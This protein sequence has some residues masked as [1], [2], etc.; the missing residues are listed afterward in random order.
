MTDALSLFLEDATGLEYQEGEWDCGF[1]MAAWMARLTGKDLRPEWAG[2]YTDAE[3][4]AAVVD[5]AGGL[6][7]AIDALAAS[8]GAERTR[9]AD[10]GVVGIVREETA[11]GGLVG[12]V[13]LGSD[14]WAFIWGEGGLVIK[15]ARALRMWRAAI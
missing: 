15:E 7:A 12:A 4:Q 1:F 5:G 10:R 13:C 2:R 8:A 3:G 9:E 14:L 11:T 6:L